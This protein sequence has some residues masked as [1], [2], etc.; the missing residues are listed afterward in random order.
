VSCACGHATVAVPATRDEGLDLARVR[1]DL[2]PLLEQVVLD[3]SHW[4]GVF[5]C[6]EC[7]GLWV[8]D[9]ITSGQ[10]DLFFFYPL[11]PLNV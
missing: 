1:R 8:E 7:G 4:L 10:M 11:R 6:R 2:E 3:P 9:C 5:R